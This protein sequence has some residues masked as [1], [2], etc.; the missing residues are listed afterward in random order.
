MD[1]VQ[2]S[3]SIKQHLSFN[4]KALCGAS[5][6]MLLLVLTGACQLAA[7]VP[8]P[9]LRAFAGLTLA[10]PPLSLCLPCDDTGWTQTCVGPKLPEIKRYCTRQGKEGSHMLSQAICHRSAYQ[11]C[12]V[13]IPSAPALP[14][15][16]ENSCGESFMH[17]PYLQTKSVMG[18][19]EHLMPSTARPAIQS[20]SEPEALEMCSSKLLKACT[21]ETTHRVNTCIRATA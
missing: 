14:M 4:S 6:G 12:G 7:S 18:F 17:G 5:V 19:P 9:E 21:Q 11:G 2:I 13:E 10:A 3:L 16:Q 1:A 8:G 15:L 20:C